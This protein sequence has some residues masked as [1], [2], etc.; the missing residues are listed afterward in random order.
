[1]EV[2]PRGTARPEINRLAFFDTN[3]LVY[4]DDASSAEKQDRSIALFAEHLRRGT[5]VVS[6]QVL[7]EYFAAV[8][9]KLGVAP[10]MAQQ[11]VEILARGRV[12]RFEARDAIAAIELHRLT[13][14]SL[15]DALIVH[16]EVFGATGPLLVAE[17]SRT[18]NEVRS[19]P[20][21]L[22]FA[23]C[24]PSFFEADRGDGG[25]QVDPVWF[26]SQLDHHAG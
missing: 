25:Q 14:I 2:Q 3:V 18:P 7:Q 26:H 8:T 19:D 24:R 4:A 23:A 15:W 11:K 9:R 12:V 5:A 21:Q 13:Q 16:A 10:E 6:P 20:F 17:Q 1:V 22:R